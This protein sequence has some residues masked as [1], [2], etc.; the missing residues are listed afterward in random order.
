MH[1]VR[2]VWLWSPYFIHN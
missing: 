1:K 2:S